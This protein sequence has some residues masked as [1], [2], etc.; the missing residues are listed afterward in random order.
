MVFVLRTLACDIP[1][2]PVC[3]RFLPEI[4]SISDGD[5]IHIPCA[6]ATMAMPSPRPIYRKLCANSL[7][8]HFLFCHHKICPKFNT[9]RSYPQAPLPPR[10]RTKPTN[11]GFLSPPRA[12]I[13]P[14]SSI[15]LGAFCPLFAPS[16]TFEQ[17]S[18]PFH[19]VSILFNR[20]NRGFLS[21]I[22]RFLA[23]LMDRSLPLARRA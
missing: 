15:R 21:P 8:S 12:T 20:F 7:H 14:S 13:K 11:R 23:V 9:L 6:L 22:H 2:N 17:P 3:Q 18:R 19:R 5:C 4:F 10:D 16:S 1:I